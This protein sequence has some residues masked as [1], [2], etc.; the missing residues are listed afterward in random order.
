MNQFVSLRN[1]YKPIKT[2]LCFIFESPPA[3]G[4]YFYDPTGRVTELLFRSLMKTL[5]NKNFDTKEK[6]LRH[7]QTEGFYLVN[8]I[9][10]PVNK[11]SDKTADQMILENYQI[12]KKD[13]VEQGLKDTPLIIVKSNVWK[14]L[15]DKLSE[16]GFIVLN[17]NEMIPFPMHYHF[18]SFKEKVRKFI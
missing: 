13:L 7:F 9:Y 2:N 12:F 15:K 11:V 10:N 8:P 6:G 14:L 17:K 5:F 4:G 16:D 18:E 1:E 3:H